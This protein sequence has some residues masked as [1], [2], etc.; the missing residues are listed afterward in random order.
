MKVRTRL[1]IF[2]SIVF[3]IIFIAIAF[4]VY[5]L[6]YNNTKSLIRNNLKRV[7]DISAMF[8]LEEDE[9][10]ETEFEKIRT[11]FREI[12]SDAEY[13]VYD[14]NNQLAF[15]ENDFNV[16]A[17]VL[18]KIQ[19]GKQYSFFVANCLCYGIFYEDNQGDFVIVAKEKQAV[20]REQTRLLLWIL[21]ICFLVG[22]IAIILLSRWVSRVAYLPFSNVIRQ[23]KNLS[24]QNLQ[25]PSPHTKDELQ[26]LTDT[27]NELLSKIAETV[28]IQ[29]NFVKYVSHEF[30]TPLTS[31]VGNLEVFSM[32]DR[33]PEEYRRLS[34]T[35]INQASQMEEILNVLLVISDLRKD[36][37]HT[38]PTR[39]DELLWEIT[40]KVK[41]CHP[42][43]DIRVKLNIED[44][45]LLSV[46]A[47]RT[48]VLMML[49]NLVENAVKY[50]QGKP[51]EISI[52]SENNRLCM[53][54]ADKGIGIMPEDLDKINK[55]FYRA[56]HTCQIEGSG[57]G[58]SI[59]LRI[60]GKNKIEYEIQ[61]EVNVG[62][63]VTLKFSQVSG[64]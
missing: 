64:L 31:L 50:S 22:T 41:S 19:A 18:S 33:S 57:I 17:A 7:A 46:S 6:Y 4:V 54:I 25:I 45:N 59:A 44:E 51:V 61:S 47:E 53:S 34:E 52:Y 3:G 63:I 32:K 23:V 55:P 29:Q 48:Q 15:G 28:V 39:L 8:Y 60:M 2:C 11:Q 49:F 5:G 13:Q 56:D 16:S 43:A 35:L 12:V 21:A 10:N 37:L 42:H 20:L 26:D 36:A 24:T 38:E 14:A 27:F 58:L 62:T 30:K 40:D 1:S 9:L